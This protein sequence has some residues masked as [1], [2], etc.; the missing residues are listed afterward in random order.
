MSN[1]LLTSKRRQLNLALSNMY[2]GWKASQS[3]LI[4]LRKGTMK[5]LR[6]DAQNAIDRF[7]EHIKKFGY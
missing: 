4:K 1:S 2:Y 6:D 3:P 5:I 7:E